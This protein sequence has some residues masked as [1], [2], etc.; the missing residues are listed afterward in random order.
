LVGDGR[1]PKAVAD[2]EPVVAQRWFDDLI[3]EFGTRG[4]EQQALSLSRHLA[5]WIDEQLADLLTQRRTAGLAGEHKG[6]G[7]IGERLV[8]QADLRRLACAFDP[9]EGD[10]EPA[11]YR[12]ASL[13][14][15][16]RRFGSMPVERDCRLYFSTSW[17]CRRRMYDDCGDSSTG[18]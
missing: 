4:A 16:T 15:R 17:C 13:K 3:D 8:E 11:L 10:E 1:I 12:A 5:E 7:R 2:H 6:D 14:T 9:F 18:L